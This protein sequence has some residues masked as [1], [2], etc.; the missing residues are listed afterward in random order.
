M[1]LEAS[2]KLCNHP[3]DRCQEIAALVCLLLHIGPNSQG[4]TRTGLINWRVRM[5]NF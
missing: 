2:T 4:N 1:A 5:V 3:Q